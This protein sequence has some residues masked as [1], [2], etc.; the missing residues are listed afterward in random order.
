MHASFKYTINI[1]L[2]YIV[3]IK[4]SILLLLILL[5]RHNYS[6]NQNVLPV[7]YYCLIT[8]L[9]SF[10]SLD[11]HVPEL[12]RTS[13]LHILFNFY[14]LFSFHLFCR[15]DSRQRIISRN[16]NRKRIVCRNDSRKRPFI[17]MIVEQES[18]VGMI[19]EK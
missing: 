1:Y 14:F 12:F 18:F 6:S 2:L 9:L 13:T 10:S 17:E 7:L 15:N 11:Y 5:T 4:V 19:V 8:L 16:N 3:F